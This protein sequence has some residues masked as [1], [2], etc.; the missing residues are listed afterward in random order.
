MKKD[1]TVL[2]EPVE[3][4][5]LVSATMTEETISRLNELVKEKKREG[6]KVNKSVLIE[7]AVNDF[8]DKLEDNKNGLFGEM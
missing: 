8:L 3:K 5:K 7:K 6:F 4:K 2:F 1:N